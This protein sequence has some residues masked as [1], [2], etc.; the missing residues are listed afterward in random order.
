MVLEH[1]ND[2][3]SNGRLFTGHKRIN[4]LHHYFLTLNL[5]MMY[6]LTT[7]ICLFFVALPLFAQKALEISYKLNA[8][9]DSIEFSLKSIYA[10]EPS[11]NRSAKKTP[12]AALSYVWDFGD[13]CYQNDYQLLAKSGNKPKP[14]KHAYSKTGKYT[15]CCYL[16]YHYANN[17]NTP[18][19]PLKLNVTGKANSTYSAATAEQITKHKE[20]DA[21][22]THNL[23]ILVEYKLP[24][25]Q[26]NAY[27]YVF[28]E[29]NNHAPIFQDIEEYIKTDRDIASIVYTNVPRTVLQ[30]I[31]KKDQQVLSKVLRNVKEIQ[32]YKIELSNT[33]RIGTDYHRL[34]LPFMVKARTKMK[35][36]NSDTYVAAVIVDET[37][38]VTSIIKSGAIHLRQSQDP[39]LITVSPLEITDLLP[40]Q[41]RQRFRVHFE[42]KGNAPVRNVHIDVQLP[43]YTDTTRLTIDKIHCSSDTFGIKNAKKSF[44]WREEGL[45]LSIFI[46]EIHLNGRKEDGII[47]RDC[48]GSLDFSIYSLKKGTIYSNTRLKRDANTTFTTRA[49]IR[50]DSNV[51]IRTPRVYIG[52]E[53]KRPTL[54]IRT[55]GSFGFSGS[56]STHGIFTEYGADLSFVQRLASH[57]GY[58]EYGFGVRRHEATQY[59]EINAALRETSKNEV[60]T[61]II[62]NRKSQIVHLF[63]EYHNN[64]TS[65]LEFGT[66]VSLTAHVLSTG[67][68]GL[69]KIS[70]PKGFNTVTQPELVGNSR[71]YTAYAWD[72]LP[73]YKAQYQTLKQVTQIS[74]YGM[75]AISLF[76]R[77]SH[78]RLGINAGVRTQA[79]DLVTVN[80]NQFAWFGSVF[81]KY[82]LAR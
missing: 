65:W 29:I 51:V 64:E 42:N 47:R 25:S 41:Q 44:E 4:G 81:L 30:N 59:Q 9:S 8:S 35:D 22:S 7:I 36:E 48:Q 3:K 53:S 1:H 14:I 73:G 32:A 63:Y 23:P 34:L 61:P 56:D 50:F 21:V 31:R 5:H 10:P 70:S 19:N 2:K 76:S 15:V 54:A 67:N 55:I 62:F 79:P 74:I 12:Q 58:G 60:Y 66:G 71:A 52:L 16:N 6:R 13:G 78:I 43:S 27:M 82:R 38:A 75:T 69:A 49:N 11:I 18:V 37:Q 40:E 45:F 28:V 72:T 17:A 46:K 68:T 77:R 39:N 33:N 20:Q 57:H 80:N 24:P 26:K